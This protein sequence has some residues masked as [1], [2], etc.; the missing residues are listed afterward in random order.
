MKAISFG[1]LN[2]VATLVQAGA[3]LTIANNNGETAIRR[4]KVRNR[5]TQRAFSFCHICFVTSIFPQEHNG[6]VCFP[7]WQRRRS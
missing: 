1:H 2:A 6:R 3:D 7:T 5:Q 4:E